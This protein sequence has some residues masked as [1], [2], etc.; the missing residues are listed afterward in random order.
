MSNL[1]VQT[2]DNKTNGPRGK[3]KVRKDSAAL[4]ASYATEKH[5]SVAARYDSSVG[6]N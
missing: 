6:F 2:A 1:G 5:Y 4:A 3:T